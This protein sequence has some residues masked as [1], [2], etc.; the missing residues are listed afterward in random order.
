MRDRIVV[1]EGPDGAGKTTLARS[2]P[3]KDAAHHH[4]SKPTGEP[5][6]E[7]YAQLEKHAPGTMTVFDRLHISEAVY[8]DVYPAPGRGISASRARLLE[9]RLLSMGAVVVLALPPYEVCRDNWRAR[10]GEEMYKDEG[11]H[12]DVWLGY[13]RCMT[14]LPVVHYD[15]TVDSPEYV[16][17]EVGLLAPPVNLG[18]G[19]G[20][21]RQGN[22][23]V[24]TTGGD[25][26]EYEDRK[27]AS[28]LE[29]A[30]VPERG[31][32]WVRAL[33]GDGRRTR[34]DFI[35]DLKPDRIVAV[36]SVASSWC[37]RLR[38]QHE[39]LPH[40]DAWDGGTHP[41]IGALLP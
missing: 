2:A 7:V 32:Y 15:Y 25:L 36:G 22:T 23:L 14:H 41:I 19:Q 30:G 38:L 18:P 24:V 35:W 9:R 3:F 16:Y 39:C 34:G 5:I 8:S 29:G 33:D 12:R 28:W 4:L 31:L 17:E 40:P 11:G 13:L 26:A 37:R 21:F 10:L 6:A 1:L 20:E 27:L